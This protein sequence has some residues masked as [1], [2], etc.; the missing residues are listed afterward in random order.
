MLV[1]LRAGLAMESEKAPVPRNCCWRS[2]Y[3]RCASVHTSTHGV[4][5][6]SLLPTE[7]LFQPLNG[8]FGARGNQCYRFCVYTHTQ[9]HTQTHTCPQKHT[10]G[11]SIIECALASGCCPPSPEVSGNLSSTSEVSLFAGSSSADEPT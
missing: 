6:C 3:T 4:C 5:S 9:M 7:L 1:H 11:P 8:A 10:S 2:L